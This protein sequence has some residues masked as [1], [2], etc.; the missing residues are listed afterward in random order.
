VV[1][2][3]AAGNASWQD[4]R[5]EPSKGGVQ[6]PKGVNKWNH[7]VMTWDG[8]NSNFKIYQNGVKVSN[9]EWE[10]R[11]T[12]G[13]LNFFTPTKPLIGAWGSNL[14]GATP[15]GWQK[16]MTGSLDELRV[17]KKALTDAEISALFQLESAGR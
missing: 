5:N 10:V 2:K 13:P 3:D 15:E 9:P 8:S 16:P 7:I 11:G 12:T 4:S 17:F 6:A 14:P 1:T